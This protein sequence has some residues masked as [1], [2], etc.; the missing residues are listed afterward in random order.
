MG[1]YLFTFLKKSMKK[2]LTLIL[3]FPLF[4]TSFVADNHLKN[5]IRD[6][7]SKTN[8]TIV[9]IPPFFKPLP[10][11]EAWGYYSLGTTI[12]V[13]SNGLYSLVFQGDHNL[14]LYRNSD[15]V[16]LW[17]SATNGKTFIVKTVF[18]DNGQLWLIDSGNNVQYRQGVQ[19]SGTPLPLSGHYQ[20][21]LQD[22]GNFVRYFWDNN[23]VRSPV[24]IATGTNGGK[25]SPHKHTLS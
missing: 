14:V 6:K 19:G 5:V 22:D 10:A 4:L 1:F 23:G 13:S 21:V 3:I 7:D 8:K 20:W 25:V 16:G 17:D 12:C 2:L 9:F 15:G 18:P 11:N 24:S